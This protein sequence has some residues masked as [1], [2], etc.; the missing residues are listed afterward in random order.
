M[1]LSGL[2]QFVGRSLQRLELRL[3]RA[4]GFESFGECIDCNVMCYNVTLSLMSLY[5]H[6]FP[7]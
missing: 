1:S 3:A 2:L 6:L 5:I 4:A 7:N